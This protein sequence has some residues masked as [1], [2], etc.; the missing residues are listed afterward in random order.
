MLI[1]D[2]YNIRVEEGRGFSNAEKDPM[3][4]KELNEEPYEPKKP[5]ARL[6]HLPQAVVPPLV[7]A[8]E[9]SSHGSGTSS[10]SSP[11]TNASKAR[12]RPPSE[13]RKKDDFSATN[14][15]DLQA[16]IPAIFSNNITENHIAYLLRL[17]P[18]S[19]RHPSLPASA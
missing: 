6:L 4:S 13:H 7:V 15:S 19:F 9:F 14:N 8:G 10:V 17:H 1:N 12:P 5:S 18:M 16:T 3:N 2:D 11:T